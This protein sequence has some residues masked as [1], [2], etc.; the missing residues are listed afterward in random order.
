MEVKFRLTHRSPKSNSMETR[1]PHH[2]G[3]L[4]GVH[5]QSCVRSFL[6]GAHVH[7]HG[8]LGMENSHVMAKVFTGRSCYDGVLVVDWLD[9]VA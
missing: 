4:K 6:F 2:G 5:R 8:A 9:A 1:L 7:V 3:V